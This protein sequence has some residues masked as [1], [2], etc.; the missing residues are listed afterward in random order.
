MGTE[1][2]PPYHEMHNII[3]DIT[4]GLVAF[5]L[6]IFKILNKSLL[7]LKAVLF[8]Q[9]ENTILLN[10]PDDDDAVIANDVPRIIID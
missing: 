1:F 8:V 3:H 5:C 2:Q 4:A 10:Q 7:S 9:D 6:G